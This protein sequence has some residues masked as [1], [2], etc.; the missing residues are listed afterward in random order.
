MGSLKTLFFFL[1]LKTFSY[2]TIIHKNY[3]I[4]TNFPNYAK[5]DKNGRMTETLRKI[6]FN[7]KSPLLH[8]PES[9]SFSHCVVQTTVSSFKM[10]QKKFEETNLAVFCNLC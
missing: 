1:Y 5:K 9:F 2:F 3:F 6:V 7:D 10:A 8:L 4:I